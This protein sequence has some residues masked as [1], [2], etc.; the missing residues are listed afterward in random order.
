MP[1]RVLTALSIAAALVAVAFMAKAGGGG[2]NLSA[3]LEDAN[4]AKVDLTAYAGKPLVINLWATWCTPCKLETPQLVGLYEKFRPRGLTI[5]GISVDDERDAVR[6]FAAQYNVTY[7]MLVGL[8]HE[9][10]LTSL[11]YRGLL[12]LSILVQ[13]DGTVS[14]QVTGLET[15]DAW[16]RKIEALLK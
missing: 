16:E 5:I 10:Y 7:P 6:A 8:G 9:D 13:A 1:G 4:G 11:G 3:V 15:T 14:S 12:P 2:V